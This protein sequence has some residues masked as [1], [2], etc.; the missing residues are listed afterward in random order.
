MKATVDAKTFSV[1]LNSTMNA[2]KHSKIPILESVLLQF[3]G[4]KCA[5]TATDMDSWLTVEIPAQG[6]TFVCSFYQTRAAAK[7]CRH[8]E[9]SLYH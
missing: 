6:D 4:G 2:M 7:T 5:M 8:Y 3:G 1:A 9:G